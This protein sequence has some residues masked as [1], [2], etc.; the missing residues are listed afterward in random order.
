MGLLFYFY[1]GDASDLDIE[2]TDISMRLKTDA[3]L[4]KTLRCLDS[5]RIC[6]VDSGSLRYYG[7]VMPLMKCTCHLFL[8][9]YNV[10]IV[11]S[12]YFQYDNFVGMHSV[13]RRLHSHAEKIVGFFLADWSWLKDQLTKES[14][15][16]WHFA[17][18]W[19]HLM[20]NKM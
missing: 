2:S 19:Q 6:H 1:F 13:R 16:Y 5:T 4:L 15:L 17:I 20:Q 7:I 18:C 8:I 12:E 3:C 11:V 14:S 10:L 9:M